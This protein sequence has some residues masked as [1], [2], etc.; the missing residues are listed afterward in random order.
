MKLQIEIAGKKRHVELAEAG[1]R[2]IWTID[3]QRLEAD[4]AEVSGGIY[5]ILIDGK[6]HQ[7]RVE[8]LGGELRG[9]TRDL[10]R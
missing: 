9:A 2:L 1:E 5:S 10:R 8:R 4:A 3:G 6:S 7:V